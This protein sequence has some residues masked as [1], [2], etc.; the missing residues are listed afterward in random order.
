M[1][2]AVLQESNGPLVYRD[3]NVEKNEGE[4]LMEVKFAAINRRDLW[5]QKGLYP[6][7]KL[8][9]ILGSDGLV[10]E[11][12]QAYLVNPNLDWGDNPRVPASSYH[13]RGLEKEGTFAEFT[14]VH[15]NRLA[16]KPSHLSDEQAAALPLGGLTAYRA[17]VGNCN[18]QSTDRVFINGIGGGVALF[19]AQFALAIGCEVHVSSSSQSKIDQA[20]QLGATGGVLYTS[21]MWGKNYKKQVGGFDVV[22]DSAGGDGFP[23]LINLCNIG[24]R[25]GIYGGTRGTINGISPQHLFF[26]Q[27]HIFGST[28]GNDQEFSKMVELVDQYKIV[29]HVDEVFRLQEINEA[30]AYMKN[31]ERFGKVII[32]CSS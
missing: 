30:F 16:K 31:Q 9:A 27:I 17:L 14:A 21:D 26:K 32:D 6:G 18:V 13:I 1:K 25:I 20:I 10:Y 12:G 3:W 24:A 5:I 19:A 29:P 4:K 11:N 2:A 22:I 7:I 15:P 8:P 28:M 23:Q